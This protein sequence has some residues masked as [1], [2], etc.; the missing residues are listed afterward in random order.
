MGAMVK[1]AASCEGGMLKPFG[2]DCQAESF[3]RAC[4]KAL[5]HAVHGFD[6]AAARGLSFDLRLRFYEPDEYT[7]PSDTRSDEWMISELLKSRP[8]IQDQEYGSRFREFRFD[9]SEVGEWFK[10]ANNRRGRHNAEVRG[11]RDPRPA[12]Q[13][14]AFA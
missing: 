2:R 8:M 12:Q 5:D 1:V 7:S 6:G 4:R 11:P 10:W 3:I 13:E 9:R 14:L